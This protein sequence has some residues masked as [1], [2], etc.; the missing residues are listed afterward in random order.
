M[1]DVN[2]KICNK[3]KKYKPSDIKRG[4]GKFCS[5]KCYY[6]SKEGKTAWNKDVPHS[7]E[8]RAKI[9]EKLRGEN[10]P[11]YG[12]NHSI[13]SKKKM[14]EAKIGEKNHNWK[15]ENVGY[16]AIHWWILQK[17]PKPNLCE[18]CNQNEPYD[19]SSKNHT[20]SRKLKEWE[21]LCRSCHS[22]NDKRIL[23]IRKMN[24]SYKN[25]EVMRK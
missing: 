10:H 6:K 19:L 9:S 25:E 2:C 11:L 3:I 15:G 17:K 18:Q 21:W 12:K 23:N 22:K 14:R 7:D 5:R 20:Y 8:T 4:S 24:K 16:Q 13:E 1:V